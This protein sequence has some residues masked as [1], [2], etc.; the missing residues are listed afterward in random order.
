MS[1]VGDS[2]FTSAAPA[3]PPP[4]RMC[5]GVACWIGACRGTQDRQRAGLRRPAHH[6]DPELAG[7]RSHPLPAVR[8]AGKGH[9][10]RVI[11]T[12]PMTCWNCCPAT[13]ATTSPNASNCGSVSSSPTGC[14]SRTPRSKSRCRPPNS[15]RFATAGCGPTKI[16][17]IPGWRAAPRSGSPTGPYRCTVSPTTAP[18]T[19]CSPRARQERLAHL[20]EG[21]RHQYRRLRLPRSRIRPASGSGPGAVRPGR[22]R[23]GKSTCSATRAASSPSPNA[24]N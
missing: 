20:A 12:L 16:P 24:R 2:E 1:T 8:S 11:R 23:P 9:V 18:W 6:A 17:R 21:R 14:T 4:W 13:S 22:R 15:R 3:P 10:E 5:C 19:C 7:H